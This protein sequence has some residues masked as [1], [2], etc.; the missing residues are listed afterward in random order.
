MIRKEGIKRAKVIHGG[1]VERNALRRSTHCFV[2]AIFH[3][4]N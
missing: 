3:R 2:V 1:A 4:K